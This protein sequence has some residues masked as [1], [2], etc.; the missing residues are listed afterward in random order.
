MREPMLRQDYEFL[1]SH[2]TI[3]FHTF[4]H[5]KANRPSENYEEIKKQ[6]NEFKTILKCIMIEYRKVRKYE[7]RFLHFKFDENLSALIN[8]GIKLLDR[9]SEQLD[10]LIEKHSLGF[11]LRKFYRHSKTHCMAELKEDEHD[12]NLII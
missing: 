5:L 3:I 12:H 8:E 10:E 7:K 4:R 1:R 2:K 11:M 9:I 6:Q